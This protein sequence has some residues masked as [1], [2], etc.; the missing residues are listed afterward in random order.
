MGLPDDEIFQ[1]QSIQPSV[2]SG[3]YAPGGLWLFGEKPVYAAY[4]RPDFVERARQLFPE[5]ELTS[6]HELRLLEERLRKERP[7]QIEAH[8]ERKRLLGEEASKT[9]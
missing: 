3:E 6:L 1:V 2:N 4:V 9:P 7:M 8:E 5:A